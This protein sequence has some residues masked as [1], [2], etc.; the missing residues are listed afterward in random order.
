MLKNDILISI[1]VPVYNVESYIS[2][3]IK[4]V[5]KQI[6][7]NF[8]C[9]LIDD[10]STDSSGTICDNICRD[11]SRFICIHKTNGGLSDARNVGI[12]KAKGEYYYFL[13]G[14]DWILP[15]VISRIVM[16]VKKYNCDIVVGSFI[17]YWDDKEFVI[18]ESDDKEVVLDGAQILEEQ[19]CKHT[20]NL[21]KISS[22]GKLFKKT[23]FDDIKFPVGKLHEDVFVAHLL[24]GKAKRV[25]LDFSPEYVYRQRSGSITTS[26][27]SPRRIDLIEALLKRLDYSIN[28]EDVGNY[29]SFV[30]KNLLDEM[31]ACTY[32][33]KKNN[34]F[35][36]DYFKKQYD[37]MFQEIKFYWKKIKN[38]N[39][40]KKLIIK[41]AIFFISP[42]LLYK[43]NNQYKTILIIRGKKYE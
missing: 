19:F 28:L 16:L 39:I 4:S 27:Y 42:S 14:D 5:Q 2:E 24:W 43:L 40:A 17:K 21:F 15:H 20:K 11:D 41:T 22:C 29:Y 1:I 3:C 25:V 9:I 36:N 33:G 12:E 13:D 10:G 6:Y 18:P 37:W 32:L 34:C 35:E 23:L 30:W 26:S 8:E 7:S 38:T 31:S